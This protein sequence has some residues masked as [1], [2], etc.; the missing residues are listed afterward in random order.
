M[1]AGTSTVSSPEILLQA[2][3]FAGGA[4]GEELSSLLSSSSNRSFL[5]TSIAA[6]LSASVSRFLNRGSS[7]AAAD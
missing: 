6:S 1:L 5:I 7:N 4:E 2:V 3:L